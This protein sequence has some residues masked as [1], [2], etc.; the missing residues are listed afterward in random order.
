[1]AYLSVPSPGKWILDIFWKNIFR[2]FFDD[3]LDHF[4][5][6]RSRGSKPRSFHDR[7]SVP[8]TRSENLM[9]HT[10]FSTRIHLSTS[11]K[12]IFLQMWRKGPIFE[13]CSSC[14]AV[15]SFFFRQKTIPG[16]TR[17]LKRVIFRSFL[18]IFVQASQ[19]H[20]FVKVSQCI[21]LLEL[22]RKQATMCACVFLSGTRYDFD[23]H[24]VQKYIVFC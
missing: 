14:V 1:M 7:A 6:P 15:D 24:F 4:S 9:S 17:P 12:Q 5:K 10:N 23:D 20:F 18:I 22:I 2:H 16:K 3:F 11:K 8:S 13:P 19:C 21:F